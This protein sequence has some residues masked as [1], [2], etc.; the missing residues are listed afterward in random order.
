MPDEHTGVEEQPVAGVGFDLEKILFGETG[1]EE[2]ESAADSAD[3]KTDDLPDDVS[4][5]FAARLADEREK[6]RKELKDELLTEMSQRTQQP[7][8][9][10]QQPVYK[11][12]TDEQLEELADRY[13]TSPAMVK[14]LLEQ[15]QKTELLYMEQRRNAQ[16]I[17]EQNEYRDAKQYAEQL[18]QQ[19]SALP[20]WDD[21]KVDQ[22]RQNHWK[23]T[24]VVLPWKDAYRLIISDAVLAG[25]IKR[26]TEQ[27]TIK[28]ITK[29]SE[30]TNTLQQPSTKR[31]P[32]IGDLSKDEFDAFIK[33]AKTGKWKQSE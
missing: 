8:Q 5:A 10:V 15:E 26:K 3:Q 9:Q 2:G 13:D 14:K 7:A 24:G 27:D 12:Y 16:I 21:T 4:K 31:K 11:D 1:V 32:S 20:A 18:V 29:R 30:E 19:T 23:Q 33:E 6:I 28:N 17:R 25:D 22:Y